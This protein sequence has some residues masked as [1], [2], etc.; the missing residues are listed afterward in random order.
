MNVWSNARASL[1]RRSRSYKVDLASIMRTAIQ[2]LWGKR[3]PPTTNWSVLLRSALTTFLI[4]VKCAMSKMRWWRKT[5]I[6]A[7]MWRKLTLYLLFNRN[8]LK[9]LENLK[10]LSLAYCKSILNA[11]VIAVLW[12]LTQAAYSSTVGSINRIRK[13][14][15]RGKRMMIACCNLICLD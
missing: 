4:Q 9:R 15:I 14:Y 12:Y 8:L 7:L 10:R 5:V 3:R 6:T 1:S 11:R 2:T 13:D